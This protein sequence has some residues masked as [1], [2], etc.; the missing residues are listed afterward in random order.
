MSNV[1]ML[2]QADHRNMANLLDLIQQQANHLAR[3]APANYRLLESSFAYLS[4]Y[5]DQ[6]H[7]PKE[8]LLYRKLLGRHPD[9]AGSLK[10]IVEEHHKLAEST[11]DLMQAIAA[12]QR[13]PHAPDERLADR[14]MEYLGL[15]RHHMRMEE[16]YFFPAALK[17]L[18]RD[19][20]AEIDFTLFDQPDPLFDAQSEQRF[21][22]L[23]EEVMRLG[24]VEKARSDSRD[25]AALLAGLQDIAAFNDAMRRSGEPVVVVRSSVEGFELE[26]DGK[27][28]VHIPKCSESRAAW[29]AYFYWKAAAPRKPAS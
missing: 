15:Y 29:C 10:D 28:L 5:P 6:C 8:D 21:G 13:D 26:H 19:D 1:V 25:E 7:H 12:T 18:S 11:T 24:A 20:F 9:M 4:G 23:R 14:L 3:H 27:V 22:E 2:L 16:Q 17:G